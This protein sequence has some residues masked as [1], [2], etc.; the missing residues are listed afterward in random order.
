MIFLSVN[1]CSSRSFCYID[2]VFLELNRSYLVATVRLT[3]QGGFRCISTFFKNRL[4]T[5]IFS[6]TE[7]KTQSLD[8]YTAIYSR[9]V[10]SYTGNRRNTEIVSTSC[11]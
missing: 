5:K 3:G 11:W 4:R 10:K 1:F 8:L 6:K 2:I 7:A 9:R